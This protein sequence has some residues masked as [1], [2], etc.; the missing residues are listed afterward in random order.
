MKLVVINKLSPARIA[1]LEKAAPGTAV[2]AYASV[3]EALPHLADADAVAMWGFHD[4]EPV[5]LA[6][7]R[8]RWVHSLSDGVEKLLTPSMMARPVILTNSRGVHDSTVSEHAMALLLAWYHRLPEAVRNQDAHQWKRPKGDTIRGKKLLIAGFGGIGKALAAK[9]RAF[10]MEIIAVK[11]SL[12]PEPLA[13]K[14]AATEDIMTVLPEADV[15]AAALPATAETEKFF[16]AEKFAAMKEGAFFLNI[17]RATVVD[18]E[19]MMDALRSGR[20]AGAAMDVFSREPLPADH[21]LWDMQNVIMTP[22]V[23]SMTPDFW[24]RLLALLEENLAAFAE[25]GPLKNVIDKTKGY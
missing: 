5:L 6:A 11:R 4:A 23:A 22:H 3:K 25:G 17:A 19:A 18:E 1:A 20:L 8:L 12:T 7:P 21:P 13:D 16:S 24:D 14:V 15:I 9:A 2:E 10:G